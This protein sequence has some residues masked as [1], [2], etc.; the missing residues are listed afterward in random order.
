LK[1]EDFPTLNSKKG[2]GKQHPVIAS[3]LRL[4]FGDRPRVPEQVQNVTIKSCDLFFGCK[5]TINPH[6]SITNN[7]FGLSYFSAGKSSAEFTCPN[8]IFG[9][10]STTW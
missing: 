10:S 5:S 2:K 3:F 9:R 6:T 4:A 1:H 8:W 7:Q